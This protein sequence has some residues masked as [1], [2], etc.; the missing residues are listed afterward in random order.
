VLTL[1]TVIEHLML[2]GETTT[3]TT[4][5]FEPST[6]STD[7][8]SLEIKR[9][10]TAGAFETGFAAH[11]DRGMNVVLETTERS[12][13]SSNRGMKLSAIDRIQRFGELGIPDDEPSTGV[14]VVVKEAHPDST[15][16][17]LE[18]RLS[19]RDTS[20]R[21]NH[22]IDTKNDSK[23]AE[24]LDKLMIRADRDIRTRDTRLKH[25][26]AITRDRTVNDQLR[27]LIRVELFEP[28]KKLRWILRDKDRRIDRRQ[29]PPDLIEM[30]RSISTFSDSKAHDRV[31]SSRADRQEEQKKELE[32]AQEPY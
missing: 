11:L 14:N 28:V 17:G 4:L 8:E 13:P 3:A 26:R 16:G 22:R 20:L 32:Q 2:R 5:T 15:L 30:D 1:T 25:G 27:Q 24:H 6:R 18:D 21:R 31:P 23:R 7:A 9:R 10:N 29:L 12:D 19:S